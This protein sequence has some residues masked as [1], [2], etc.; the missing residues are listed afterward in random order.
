MNMGTAS[1]TREQ[2][3]EAIEQF[4]NRIMEALGATVADE[5]ASEP[6]LTDTRFRAI[7]TGGYE[8]EL[9]AEDISLGTLVADGVVE[10]FRCRTETGPGPWVSYSGQSYSHEDFAAEMRDAD[11]LP[12]VVHQG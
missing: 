2:L 8:V 7:S 3:N 4:A 11:P 9:D 6:E 5:E 1:L 12:R 10:Y